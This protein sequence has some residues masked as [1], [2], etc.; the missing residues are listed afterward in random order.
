MGRR[1][2]IRLQICAF[3]IWY[4]ASILDI[5]LVGTVDTWQ[6][7]AGRADDSIDVS[8]RVVFQLFVVADVQV[9]RITVYTTRICRAA[10][11]RSLT[12]FRRRLWNTFE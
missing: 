10:P 11:L 12:L 8:G 9:E 3:F 1:R 2:H 4:I 5:L 7:I 6:D